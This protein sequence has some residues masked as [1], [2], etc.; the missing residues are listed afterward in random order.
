MPFM[1][2][3]TCAFFVLRNTNE[4]RMQN[5]RIIFNYKAVELQ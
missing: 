1:L 2:F 3:Q 5:V 4:D